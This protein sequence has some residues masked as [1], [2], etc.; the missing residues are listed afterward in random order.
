MAKTPFSSTETAAIT[1]LA[2]RLADDQKFA[3]AV[4]AHKPGD[5]SKL[6]HFLAEHGFK[7]VETTIDGGGQGLK[8]NTTYRICLCSTIITGLCICVSY[9]TK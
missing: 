5:E 6:K 3:H 7:G 2:D 9:T 8:P 4:A 1:K